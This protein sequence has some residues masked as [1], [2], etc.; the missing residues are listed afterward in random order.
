MIDF[1]N[2]ISVMQADLIAHEHQIEQQAKNPRWPVTD[3]NSR[4]QALAVKSEAVAILEI[5]AGDSRVSEYI[6]KRMEAGE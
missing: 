4:R 6:T 1:A 2:V 5:V 3:T